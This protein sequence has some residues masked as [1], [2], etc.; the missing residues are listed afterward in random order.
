MTTS[1]GR[2]IPP[3]RL[4]NLVNPVVRAVL[5]SPLHWTLDAAS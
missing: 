1:V 2:R 5:E 3:Q 4:I